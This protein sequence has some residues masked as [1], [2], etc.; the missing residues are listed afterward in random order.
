[1]VLLVLAGL[2][3]LQAPTSIV[4]VI[5]SSAGGPVA[6]ARVEAGAARGVAD[7]AGRV[8]LTIAA[9]VTVTVQADGFLP[10]AVDLP[11]PPPST[12]EITLEPVPGLE[13]EVVADATR[14]ATRLADQP[15]RVEVI[16]GEEIEE[17]ALMTPGSVAMLLAET[18]GLR[19]QTTAPSLGAANVRVQGLRGRYTQ[20]LA[21]GLPLYGSQ[22]DSFSLLQVPPLDLARVEIVKG[23]AS[24][25]YGPT[26][27][28]GVVNLVTRRPAADHAD[29]LFNITSQQGVDAAAFAGRAPRG[30][31][32]WTLLGGYHGQRA[33]DVDEDG[34]SDV[35]RY[36][37]GVA[38]PRLFYD[39]GR[40]S[41][42]F[43]TLGVNAENRDGGTLDGASAPDGRPFVQSLDTRRVD[44]GLVARWV[45]AA[46]RV[47]AARGSVA[48]TGQDRRFGEVVEDG[49]RIVWFGEAS[50]AGVHGRHSWV[51]GGAI[52]QDRHRSRAAPG[53]AF[54]FTAPGIFAQDDVR[55]GDAVSA[56]ASVR[57][58]VHSEYGTLVNPRV[59]LL[60]RPAEAWTVRVSTGLGAF[61]PTP[62]TEE[63]EEVGFSRLIA[64]PLD[65]ER[66]WA[67]S[68][69][70]SRVMGPLELT[71]TGF[72]SR[73]GDPVQALDVGPDRFTL[74]NAVDPQWV[75]GAEVIARYRI[76]GA[77]VVGTYAWTRATEPHLSRGGRRETPLTPRHAVTFTAIRESERWGRIGLEAYYTGRQAL[78][79][80]PYRASS[81][82]YVLVGVLGER[83]IGRLR[84][85][86][87]AENL[88]HVRQTKYAPL[89]RPTRR[90]DGRWTVDA[91]APLEG[92]V[93][94]GGVRVVVE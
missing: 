93:V 94:N 7:E 85:F 43:A 40:G 89:V 70:V 79:D 4:L 32:G 23:A 71:A 53:A 28:G 69:D 88:G 2:L 75:W 8:T 24:A 37:R 67:A 45:T 78:D 30:G 14:T 9:P 3:A 76:E 86:V 29:L 19:V 59:S 39:S 18:T 62:F 73:V 15:L 44:G 50:V 12:L 22:G 35:A 82:P 80:D 60:A 27:L 52:T 61:A 41:T 91:W 26:A 11:A 72:A 33:Q 25:L 16:D 92:V 48:R 65:V 13:E 42:L 34:W 46:G 57:V 51:V 21:D 5:R 56:S 64:G 63:T 83:R 54:T 49:A 10:A 90:P 74:V 17:K 68:A 31:W 55:I 66:A 81:R 1:V 47:V 77:S 58:D 6:G 36:S 87:N 84:L 38:R 20:L